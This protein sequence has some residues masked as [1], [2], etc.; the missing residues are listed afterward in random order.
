MKICYNA[1]KL[2]GKLLNIKNKRYLQAS[3]KKGTYKFEKEISWA[4]DFSTATM[5]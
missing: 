5:F 4:S 2:L 1:F 3:K